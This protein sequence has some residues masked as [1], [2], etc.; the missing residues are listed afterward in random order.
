MEYLKITIPVCLHLDHGT[1]VENCLE[2]I[3]AGFTSVMI[4]ASRYSLEKI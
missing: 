2:A 1:S 3:N 4:D